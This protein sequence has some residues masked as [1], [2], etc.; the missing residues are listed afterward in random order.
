MIFI[1]NDEKCQSLD[2]ASVSGS[3]CF[4]S[5]LNSLEQTVSSDFTN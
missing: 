3:G 4:L 1:F 2:L 5:Y